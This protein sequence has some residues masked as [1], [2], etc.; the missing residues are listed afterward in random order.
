MYRDRSKLL[1]IALVAIVAVVAIIAMVS[2]GRA[3]LNG[4]DKDEVVDDSANRALLTT[5]M[6]RSV[7]MTVRGPI[8]AEEDF[9]SY[10]VEISPIGRRMSIYEGYQKEILDANRLT[11]S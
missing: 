4:G 5:E 6:D 2:L 11:N 8:V 9:R 7:R 10:E 3:L 1:P